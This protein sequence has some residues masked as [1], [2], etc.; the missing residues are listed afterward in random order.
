M[1]VTVEGIVLGKRSVGESN[2]FLDILTDEYG[3]IE[4]TAHGV[5]KLTNR[6]AGI[7]SLFSYCVF[8]LSRSGTRYTLNSG[9]PKY[10]FHGISSDM[11]S[12]SLA[13]YFSEVLKDAAAS[14]QSAEGLLRFTAV[15]LY[16]LEK[17]RIDRELIKAVF[18]LHLCSVLGFMPDLRACSVC[19]RYEHDVMYFD[20]DNSCI[21]CGG[22]AGEGRAEE[23]LVPV[24]RD[25]LDKMRYIAYTDTDRVYKLSADSAVI[26]RLSAV[27]ELYLLKT[28]DRGFRSLDYYKNIKL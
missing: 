23:G 11:E 9:E 20:M 26:S 4:V 5:K 13:A 28:F 19:G 8:C 16:E 24:S 7:S 1:L 15:T 18:E 2:C 21:I 27:T 10:S 22:C 14:E 6:N 3:V 17:K 25:V 12:F